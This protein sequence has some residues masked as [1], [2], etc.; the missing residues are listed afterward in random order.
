M[1]SEISGCWYASQ[2]NDCVAPS[3][4]VQNCIE[5]TEVGFHVR[6]IAIRCT[7]VRQGFSN[8]HTHY[9][10][11]MSQSATNGWTSNAAIASS[12]EDLHCCLWMSTVLQRTW[13]GLVTLRALL[14]A[15]YTP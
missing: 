2:V 14:I 10:E 13:R 12:N 9:V 8:I 1:S 15:L 5:V 11:A 4:N 3:H 7:A 6:E